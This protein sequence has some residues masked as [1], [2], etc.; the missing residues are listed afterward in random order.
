LRLIDHGLCFHE[1]EKLRSVIWDFAGQTIPADLL[2][3][4]GEL[5]AALNETDGLRQRLSA[6]LSEAELLALQERGRK[7]LGG[8]TFPLPPEDRRAFP[9]PPI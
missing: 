8:Q 9:Y 4:L 2:K 6:H 1:E 3:G 5:H 7:L